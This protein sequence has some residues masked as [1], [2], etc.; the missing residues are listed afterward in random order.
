MSERIFGFAT[1]SKHKAHSKEIVLDEKYRKI[2]QSCFNE[3]IE[4]WMLNDCYGSHTTKTGAHSNMLLPFSIYGAI[5]V[6][7]QSSNN[8]DELSQAISEQ[9]QSGS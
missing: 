4:Y 8:H 1:D 3:M 5:W 9:G 2:I 7:A 6:V